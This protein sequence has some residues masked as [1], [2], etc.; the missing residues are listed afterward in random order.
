[1]TPQ[2]GGVAPEGA[3]RTGWRDRSLLVGFALVALVV[4]L[5]FY[6]G[7]G[8]L[9]DELYFIACGK[10][11]AWGYVDHPPGAPLIA[12]ASQ[13]IFGDTLFAIRFVPILFAVAQLV[14]TG[15]TTRVMGGGRY[16]QFLAC[17]CVFGAPQYFGTWLNTDMFMTLGWASC[18]WAAARIFTGG[19]ERLWL[20]FGLFA[21]LALQGKHAML[22]FLVA[23]VAGMAVSPQ[24]K[25]LLRPWPWYGMVIALLIALPNVIWEYKHHWAT[26]E[27]LSNIAKSDK[28]LV[29]GPWQYLNANLESLGML[30]LL[31]WVPGLVWCLFLPDGKRFRPLG[32]TWIFAF[33]L[34]I[35]LKGKAYYLAPAYPM[36]FAAGSVAIAKGLGHAPRAL[37]L[38]V[39]PALAFIVFLRAIVGWPFAMPMMPVEKFIA[40][41]HALH[42]VPERTET[43]AVNQ[44]PQQY[45]DMFGWPELAASVA[46]I[47]NSIPAGQ[48]ESCGIY[49]RNYGEAAA[50]DYFGREHGLPHAI[51]G[52]QSY[53]LWGPF[54]YSGDCMIFIGNLP[55]VLD[56]M[57]DSVTRVAE[58][59]QPYAMPYEYHRPIF[60]CHGKKFT[61]LQ[62]LWPQMKFWI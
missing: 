26:Y 36:L 15:L 1:V 13:K 58:T 12:W 21:G 59:N 28:N 6:R 42:A 53:W 49:G 41:E 22:F 33:V 37:R 55:S 38:A 40:Y 54:P 44:L 16:A 47:Y 7:Y 10:H 56:G 51:S 43:A 9:R 14:L 23:F 46:R 18:A 29:L 45:A 61:S 52:H 25:L 8:F 11:L 34:F 4:H 31:V 19:S 30:T 39:Q 17:L 5:A 2:S 57:Y 27:L 50:I 48:R 35:A 62:D 20:L 3:A 24:R 60:L 32:W